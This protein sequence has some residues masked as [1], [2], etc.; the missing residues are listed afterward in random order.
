L[1]VASSDAGIVAVPLM[2]DVHGPQI[3]TATLPALPMPPRW[4]CAAVAGPV[5][6]ANVSF[7]FRDVPV[8]IPVNVPWA[9]WFFTTCFGTSWPAFSVAVN[10]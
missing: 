8:R 5:S 4:M 1:I 2:P 9:A 10:R 6:F 7:H 3:A